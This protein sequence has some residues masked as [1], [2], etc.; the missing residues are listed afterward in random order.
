M[1]EGTYNFVHTEEQFAHVCGF[2]DRR[3]NFPFFGVLLDLTTQ[4]PA[5]NLMPKGYTWCR[6][7]KNACKKYGQHIRPTD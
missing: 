4:R 5:D 7:I 3:S 2:D 1:K 6:T